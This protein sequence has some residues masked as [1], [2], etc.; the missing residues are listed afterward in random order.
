M[1]RSFPRLPALLRGVATAALGLALAIGGATAALAD[2][3]PS[4]VATDTGSTATPLDGAG[5]VTITADAQCKYSGQVVCI[6]YVLTDA[7]SN[8]VSGVKLTATSASGVTADMTTGDDGKFAFAVTPHADYT[9]TLDTSS[10]PSGVTL[11][12]DATLSFTDV[13]GQKPAKFTLDGTFSGSESN[14]IGAQSFGAQL[15]AAFSQGLLL[16]LLLALAAIGLSLVYGTT[17]LSNFAHGEQVTLGGLMAFIFTSVTHLPFWVAT[18]IAVVIGAASGYLQDLA[19][20]RPLRKRGFGLG[21]LM[22]VSIGLSFAAEY[23]FQYFF[24]GLPVQPVP[25]PGRDGGPFELTGYGYWSA[26]I[27]IVVLVGVGLVLSRT[28]VGRAI[29]AVADNP[30]LASASGIDNDRVI[31]W[32]WTI[33]MGISALAGA[34]YAAVN[35]GVLW[36]TGVSLLLLM[37]AAVTL[38]GIGTAFG[39]FVGSMIIGVVVQ[40]VGVWWAGDLKYASALLVFIIILIFR[41]QGIFGR[42]ARI[43]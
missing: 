38:G 37:F 33:A 29:R 14:Q 26:A 39:A 7:N 30:A 40:V 24:G 15:W 20:W 11:T 23:L 43:G 31:R 13:V 1:T 16:G 17:G 5:A 2:T 12:S 28:R 19:I 27:A 9:V 34:L 32:V 42:R 35:N 36:S 4:P 8:P 21:Q 3:T 10:L 25:D 22:L 6:Q 18:L 41:P